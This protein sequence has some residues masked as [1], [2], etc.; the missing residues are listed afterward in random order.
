[1]NIILGSASPRRKD[2]LSTITDD[3]IVKV[4]DINEEFLPGEGPVEFSERI[5]RK[6][7]DA[8]TRSIDAPDY[9]DLIISSDTIVTFESRILGKP[10]DRDDAFEILSYLSGRT[11]NVIT[12]IS[13]MYRKDETR[14]NTDIITDHE[15]TSVTFRKLTKNDIKLY[16]DKVHYMDKAG[17][18]AIQE[19]GDMIIEKIEGSMTNVIGF[20]MR[21][22]FK[23]C[24]RL[25]LID[26]L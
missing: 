2:L 7:L 20:P 17:A 25:D 5:S 9:P 12:G 22:F 3:F 8:V 26:I 21:L 11:H 16:M 15:S 6:K 19:H 10:I 1:M 14:E 18:Y 23:M 4:P 24:M 13:I